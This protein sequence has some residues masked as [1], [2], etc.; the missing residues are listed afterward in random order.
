MHCY[1]AIFDGTYAADNALRPVTPVFV[2]ATTHPDYSYATSEFI[3]A[4]SAIT[5]VAEYY[6]PTAE[7]NCSFMIEKLK[8]YNRT[9]ATLNDVAVGEA[10]DYDL[11]TYPNGSRNNSAKDETRNLIYQYGCEQNDCD[12]LVANGRTG[13]I[14]AAKN[15]GTLTS[16]FKNYQTLQNATY[17]YTTGPFGNDAPL[18]P[19]TTYALMK[20]VS[21]YRLAA[22]DADTCEDLMTLVTFDVYDIG[23]TDTFCVVKIISTSKDDATGATIKDNIDKANAFIA[24]HDEIKCSLA[25]PPCLCKPGDANNDGQVNVGDAVYLI[26]FVFK[27]GPAPKPYAK[28][29]GDA[30]KDCQANVGDA[31]YVINFVFKGGP[32]P[33]PCA[34]WVAF[35]GPY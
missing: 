8:F 29:S 28:C 22:V 7:A 20:N 27:G 31:V 25:P 34:D 11:A 16:G 15:V 21:G 33:K 32:A 6:F 12:T 1:R 2:D 10:L 5:F 30:N 17:V 23:V 3:T 35:C 14:A 24:A 19:D 18:P 4:D 13:A 9:D 26:N